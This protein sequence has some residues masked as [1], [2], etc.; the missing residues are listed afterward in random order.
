MPLALLSASCI[1]LEPCADRRTY[2]ETTH[3]SMNDAF[4]VL[5]P[6]VSNNFTGSSDEGTPSVRHQGHDKHSKYYVVSG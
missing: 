3:S 1:Y 6:C 4:A 2:E 5:L